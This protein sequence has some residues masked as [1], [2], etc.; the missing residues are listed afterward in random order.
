AAGIDLEPI[1][2]ID[3]TDDRWEQRH[4]S[5]TEMPETARWHTHQNY[6]WVPL[7]D[8]EMAERLARKDAERRAEWKRLSQHDW[9]NHPEPRPLTPEDLAHERKRVDLPDTK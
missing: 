3:V 7:T 6:K 1:Q 2:P 5:T 4:F 8:E 9:Y